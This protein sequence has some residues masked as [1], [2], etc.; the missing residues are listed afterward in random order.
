MSPL[1]PPKKDKL[2]DLRLIFEFHTVFPHNTYLYPLSQTH[3]KSHTSP[4]RSK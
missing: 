2:K 4:V 3:I 1:P